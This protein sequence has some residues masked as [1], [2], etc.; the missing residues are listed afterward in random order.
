MANFKAQALYG[1]F[2]RLGNFPIDPSSFFEKKS[3]LEKYVKN[4]KI[5][6]PGQLLVVY[7]DKEN[8]GIWIV[9]DFKE[10][11]DTEKL[12]KIVNSTELVNKVEEIT[13]KVES[14]SADILKYKQETT[15]ANNK[16]KD[17]IETD[18]NAFE[19]STNKK[20]EEYNATVLALNK[21]VVESY[22]TKEDLYN[23]VEAILGFEVPDDMDKVLETFGEINNWVNE[24][25]LK[26][27]EIVKQHEKDLASLQEMLEKKINDNLTDAIDKLTAKID[28][29]VIKVTEKHAEDINTLQAQT[30]GLNIAIE[31]VSQ[32][33]SDLEAG[34]LKGVQQ[35]IE[36][37]F[38][39]YTTELISQDKIPSGSVVQSV[40]VVV[41]RSR[42]SE[43]QNDFNIYLVDSEGVRVS[44][45]DLVT[46]E[47]YDYLYMDDLSTV[48]NI[49][50]TAL[51]ESE[52]EHIRIFDFDVNFET[53]YKL[54]N[55]GSNVSIDYYPKLKL[56]VNTNQA[57]R[58]KVYINY[59]RKV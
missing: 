21:L 26:F 5:V 10:T 16:F 6:Y 59:F 45:S 58:G 22:A 49:D 31:E 56:S 33:V 48:Y 2:K 54:G 3:D 17:E 1:S 53:P 39:Q 4:S 38:S 47:N 28:S 12:I 25:E 40:R 24:H 51:K 41:E 50:L 27:E 13:G 46:N 8:N 43:I 34:V 15:D 32:R 7:A 42:Q 52:R 19:T 30:S 23:E 35:T 20:L 29:E 14:I 18:I 11:V 44:E 36:M 57:L 9:P 37:E 55:R